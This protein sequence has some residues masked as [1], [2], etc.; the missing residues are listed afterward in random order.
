MA[1]LSS[2]QKKNEAIV[3]PLFKDYFNNTFISAECWWWVS[4]HGLVDFVGIIFDSDVIYCWS[5]EYFHMIFLN[6]ICCL[7]LCC[8]Q[9]S[10]AFHPFL[11]MDS[12]TTWIIW[13]SYWTSHCWGG[14]NHGIDKSYGLTWNWLLK[15]FIITFWAKGMIGSVFLFPI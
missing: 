7:H 4:R 3:V 8:I 12:W 5:L 9:G 10:I 15:L 13:V 2:T 14:F 11:W 1:S 6:L